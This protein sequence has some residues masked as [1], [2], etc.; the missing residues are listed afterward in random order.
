[1]AL[2]LKVRELVRP[3]SSERDAMVNLEAIGRTAANADVV[4]GMDLG[5]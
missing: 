5:A 4:A 1:M 3:A 2:K